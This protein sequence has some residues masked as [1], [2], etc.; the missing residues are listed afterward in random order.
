MVNT[1]CLGMDAPKYTINPIKKGGKFMSFNIEPGPGHY[2]SIDNSEGKY[3][4]S[5]LR[6]TVWPLWGNSK[7]ERFK[8]P[9]KYLLIFIYFKLYFIDNVL[10]G[11]ADYDQK[12]L[13]N[14]TGNTFYSNIK[15][16]SSKSM[17]M[18]F[19][20]PTNKYPSKSNIK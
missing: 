20:K 17:G 3:P 16:S 2:E 8:S 9:S 11:P 10:P 13:I 5:S 4:C 6:N 12:P 19:R 14:G 15:S 18:K 1:H 7:T